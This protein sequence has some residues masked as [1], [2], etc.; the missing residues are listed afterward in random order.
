MYSKNL[1][2]I[3]VISTFA[4]FAQTVPAWDGT[5]HMLVAQIA[6]NRLSDAARA[7]V[8]ELAAKLQKD[9]ASYNG[10]NIA[11][12]PDDI[13]DRASKSSFQGQFK[14]WHYI[15]IGC[16]PHD[17]DVLGNPPTLTRTN[18]DVVVALNH[19][20]GLIRSK[21][22]DDLVPNE[23]VAL[24]LVSHFVG[25]IHQPLHT[26]AR[27][28]PNP[29]PEDKKDDAGGNGVSIANIA[30]TPWGKN[31]HTFW[32]EAYRRYFENGE[33]KAMPKV[34]QADEPGSA[35]LTAWMKRLE[36]DA[37]GKADLK[38]DSKNWALEVHEI[39]CRQVYGK[40][41]APYDAKDVKLTE[42]YVQEATS[43]ARRQIVLAGYRLAALLNELY[44]K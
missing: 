20:V 7:R 6:R 11:C 40:L 12:W 32:D 42:S 28:N 15:D 4:F 34:N 8:D 41:G 22:F 13:K 3:V 31:L 27:Y 17:P 24:A 37:P 36:G 10:V 9:G 33:V 39:A 23:S 18:G 14:P 35:E 38:F 16:E 44:G 29:K 25:D 30:D 1:R 21:K 5:G 2:C 19:C 26:T 43:L